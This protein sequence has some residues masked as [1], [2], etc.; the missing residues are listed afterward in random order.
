MA[1]SYFFCDTEMDFTKSSQE[2]TTPIY[3]EVH[4]HYFVYKLLPLQS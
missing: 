4:P 3:Q 1:I 2:I